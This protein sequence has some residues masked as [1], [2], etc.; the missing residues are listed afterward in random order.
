MA[1]MDE[2]SAS[3]PIFAHAIG[4]QMATSQIAVDDSRTHIALI[5]CD[6]R[7]GQVLWRLA[8]CRVTADHVSD[9]VE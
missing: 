2:R 3:S 6:E 7:R 9:H 1:L 8:A 5:G 4:R